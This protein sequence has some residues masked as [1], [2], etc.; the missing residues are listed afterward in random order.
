M[1]SIIIRVGGQMNIEEISTPNDI[2]QYM[3]E[4]I[5]YGWIDYQKKKHDRY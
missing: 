2:L 3:E 5:N 1:Y 4:H